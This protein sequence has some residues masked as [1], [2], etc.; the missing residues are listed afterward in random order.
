MLIYKYFLFR[1]RN[2]I[3]KRIEPT[4]GGK[5]KEQSGRV[6]PIVTFEDEDTETGDTTEWKFCTLLNGNDN[7]EHTS[8]LKKRPVSTTLTYLGKRRKTTSNS[9][10]QQFQLIP[11]KPLLKR[12][13]YDDLNSIEFEHNQHETEYDDGDAEI[14]TELEFA[15]AADTSIEIIDANNKA[16]KTVEILDSEK[17]NNDE[18]IEGNTS[19]AQIVSNDKSAA[20]RDVVLEANFDKLEQVIG[21]CVALAEQCISSCA[22]QDSNEVFGK[23]VASMVKELPLEKRMK[24]R[25]DIIQ[26]TGDLIAKA[27]KK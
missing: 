7:E 22:N 27:M 13:E 10:K 25:F 21:K 2:E 16:E 8:S 17:V 4:R 14:L 18:N 15:D 26:F 24:A 23:F 5:A 20:C 12:E 11:K 9:P 1:T 3:I 6:T 19:G